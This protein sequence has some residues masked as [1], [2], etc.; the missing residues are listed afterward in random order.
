MAHEHHPFLDPC[1]KQPLLNVQGR[2]VR[3]VLKF[4]FGSNLNFKL[5]WYVLGQLKDVVL[6]FNDGM[7]V[8]VTPLITNLELRNLALTHGIHRKGFE[9]LSC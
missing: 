3:E 9:Q 8:V 4:Y 6:Y 1:I 5:N 2:K 7:I